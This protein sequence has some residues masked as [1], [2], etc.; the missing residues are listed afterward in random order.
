MAVLRIRKYGDPVL[1][2]KA[3]RVED[4]DDEIR[5]LAQD[6][7]ETMYAYDGV[8]LAA[9]QVGEL[10][11][12]VVVDISPHD[13][14]FKPLILINP[15][16]VEGYGEEGFE[17]GCLSLPDITAEVIRPAQVLVRAISLEGDEVEI[18]ADGLLARVLQHEID[19]LDG[20]LFIDRLP[21]I[22]RRLLRGQLKKLEEE[23]LREME[24][25]R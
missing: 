25:I 22:R 15:V 14:T 1:R 6:M 9:N 18:E 4:I 11:K 10:R 13:P 16:V 8:G 12:V 20:V 17:E 2:R 19:H 24:G 3:E 7:M 23:T 21:F 5:R